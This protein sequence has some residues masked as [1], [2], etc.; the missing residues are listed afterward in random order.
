MLTV[1]NEAVTATRK[2]RRTVV[3]EAAKV[4]YMK[5]PEKGRADTAARSRKIYEKHLEKSG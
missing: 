4:S 1:Q 3:H 2:T 5:E